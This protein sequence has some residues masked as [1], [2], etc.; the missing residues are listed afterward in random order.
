MSPVA[1]CKRLFEHQTC[2]TSRSAFP[3]IAAMLATVRQLRFVPKLEVGIK[4]SRTQS[5]THGVQRA[6]AHP[7]GAPYHSGRLTPNFHRGTDDNWSS[8][9]NCVGAC[10]RALACGDCCVGTGLRVRVA[11]G[12]S[13][14]AD[15]LGRRFCSETLA[16]RRVICSWLA[17]SCS[18]P[19][20]TFARSRAIV[21]SNCASS[22]SVG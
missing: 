2:G 12:G 9:G 3:T 18:I 21:W 8:G 20:S 13:G 4:N 14:G 16:I 19:C 10:G 17:L 7:K 6:A 22:G 11:V 1:S 5:V 15:V